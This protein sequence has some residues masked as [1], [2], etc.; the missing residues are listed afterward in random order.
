MKKALSSILV[1]VMLLG[2]VFAL[3][4]CSNRL[5]GTYEAEIFGQA[6]SYE[7]EG[8]TVKTTLKSTT[9]SGEY[10]IEDDKIVITYDDEGINTLLDMLGLA[11]EMSFNQGSDNDGNFIELNGIRFDK[12]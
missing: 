2:C 1:C 6:V 3:A 11:G 8:D 9:Y 4:S 7:F 5:Y 10:S 12:E